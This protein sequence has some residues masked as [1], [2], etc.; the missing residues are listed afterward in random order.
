[1][2]KMNK[3]IRREKSPSL[4]AFL[5][6]F[7]GMGAFYNGNVLKGLSYVLIFVALIVLLVHSRGNEPIVFAFLLA[8]FYI[9]QIIDS[10]N[11][12][13]KLSYEETD[14]G[15]KD[16]KTSLFASISILILGI[17]FLMANLDLISYRI[18]TELWPL[19]LVAAGLHIVF[20]Y[21]KKTSGSL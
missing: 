16:T 9:F 12:A 7:P 18:I 21:Y 15:E 8:G 10:F 6:I 3:N 20:K 2:D 4:A 11:E 1:M 5:S 14:E 13:K 19:V 17:I